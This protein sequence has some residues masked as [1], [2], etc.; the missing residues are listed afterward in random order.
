M[1]ASA[2]TQGSAPETPRSMARLAGV[3][4]LLTFVT[5]SLALF[6]RSRVGNASGVL[7]GACYVVVTFLFYHLFKPV[8]RKLS[9]LAALISLIGCA[10]GPLSLLV[11][12]VSRINPLAIFGF[13]CLL[14][15]YLILNSTFLPRALGWLMVFAGAGWLTFLSPALARQLSPF[16]FLPGLLGEG[17]LTVWLLAAGVDEASWRKQALAGV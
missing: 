17:A 4:Y 14:I 13:Y 3:F 16:N 12:A 11:H 15:G 1:N 2:T 8:S 9:L 10:I 7:A 5:G 6:A